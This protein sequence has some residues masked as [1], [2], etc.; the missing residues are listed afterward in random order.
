[1]STT[2]A[3]HLIERAMVK[4]RIIYPGETVPASKV[5]Q[6]LAELND[7]LES[8]A[9]EDIMILADVEESFS[10]VVGQASYTYGTGGN[11]NSARPNEI[12]DQSFIRSGGSDFPVKKYTMDVY[13]RRMSK[14]TTGRPEILAY[15]PEY[16]LGKIYLWPTPDSTDSLYLKVSKT[17]A[18]FASSATEVDLQPGYRRAIILG[19]AQ[20]ISPNF[21]K[22]VT[23]ELAALAAQAKK[24]IKSKNSKK[25]SPRGNPEFRSMMSGGS[26]YNILAGY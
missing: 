9:I 7:L 10:L 26:R 13:R 17:I 23:G 20:E 19:L 14:T 16:P 3:S 21:G 12:K 22:K 8:W 24:A 4:A 6:V 25:P 18:S 11:F 15:T 2:S 5:S 1:M